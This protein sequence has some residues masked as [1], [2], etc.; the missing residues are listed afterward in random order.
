M[1]SLSNLKIKSRKS[2]VT[3]VIGIKEKSQRVPKK[4]FKLLDNKPLYSWI[5]DTLVSIDEIVEIFL[6]IEGKTLIEKIKSDYKN[7]KKIRVFERNEDL[8]GHKTPMTD[9]I[10]STIQFSKTDIILN[11]HVTNPFLSK[12]SIRGAIDLFKKEKKPVFSVNS[13]QSRFYDEDLNPLNHNINK[14]IQTQDLEIMYEENSCLYIFEKKEFIS[15]K[16]RVFSNSI[17]YPI[18]K[19][20]AVDIDTQEDWELAETIARGLS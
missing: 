3:V 17:V 20:E 10:N 13:H 12:N 9:I 4:N 15:N 7:V 16:I 5:L 18:N 19:I 6:N 8:I 1:I 11:T 2:M 14:L